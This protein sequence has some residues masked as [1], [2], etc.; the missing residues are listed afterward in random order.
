MFKVNH[1]NTELMYWMYLK[2]AAKTPE[3][4]SGILIVILKP[5]PCNIQHIAKA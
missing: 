1:K 5:V 2:L 4:R 3:W